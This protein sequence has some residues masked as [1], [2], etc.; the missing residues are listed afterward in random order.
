LSAPPARLARLRHVFKVSGLSQRQIASKLGMTEQHLSNVVR[1]RQ[2]VGVEMAAKVACAF[3]VSPG[4]LLFGEEPDD[5]VAEPAAPYNR[6]KAIRLPIVGR[7]SA[8][9]NSNVVWDPIDPPE[10]HELPAGVRLIEVRGDSMRP[11]VWPGQK[12]IA[13]EAGGELRD[14]DLAV[15]ELRD[16]RQLFKRWWAAGDKVTLTSLRTDE[17]EPPLMV[18]ARQV[19]RTWRIIGVLFS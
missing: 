17:P 6:N 14:G 10:W 7:A 16:G 15:V 12:V 9:P 8:G 4:W 13:A 1:G 2:A 18:T 3:G 11:L 5:G 19:R